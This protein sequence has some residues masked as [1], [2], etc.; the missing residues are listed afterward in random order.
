MSGSRE[1]LVEKKVQGV[2]GWLMVVVLLAVAFGSAWFF[3]QVVYNPD[4]PEHSM[5]Y[6]LGLAR[7]A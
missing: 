4:R 3:A 5:P 7:P 2:P 6:P 1:R